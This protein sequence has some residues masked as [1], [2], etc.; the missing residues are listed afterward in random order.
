MASKVYFSKLTKEGVQKLASK[1]IETCSLVNKRTAIKV[2]FGEE[3]NS[4]FVS[5]EY[6]QPIIN[7]IKEQTNDYFLTDTNT[8]YRGMRTNATNHKRIAQE[9]GFSKLNTPIVIADGEHGT[10]EKNIQINLKHF[11]N[12]KIGRAISEAETMFVVSHFKGHVLY[13]FGGALKNLAMGGA[14]RAG[15]LAMHSKISPVVGE[16]CTKCGVCAENCDVDAIEITEQGAKIMEN[17][18]G[19]ARCIAVC[20]EGVIKV[21]WHGATPTE[22]MERGSEYAYAVAKDK[23]CMYIT[24]INNVTKDCDC[25]SDSEIIGKDIGIIAGFDPVALDQAAYDLLKQH[26]NGKDIFQEAGNPDGTTIINYAE[27]LGMGSREYEIEEI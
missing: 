8:L 26:N 24:F 16:G 20:P 14:S 17:C 11:K 7:A 13:G 25:L 1:L 6:I 23:Q 18:I 27:E 10:D 15:K 4:R 5:P 12:A 9:H 2:H 21:P 3:G 19:C 22:A